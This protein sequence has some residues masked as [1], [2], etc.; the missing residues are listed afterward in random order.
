MMVV[1]QRRTVDE[2]HCRRL[3]LMQRRL[4]HERL[5]RLLLMTLMND[6]SHLLENASHRVLR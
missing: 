2:R 5:C 4:I 6:T 1:T 3:S